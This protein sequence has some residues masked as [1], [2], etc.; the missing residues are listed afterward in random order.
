MKTFYG[1]AAALL[2]M[3]TALPVAAQQVLTVD[4]TTVW[5]PGADRDEGGYA[6][7]VREPAPPPASTILVIDRQDAWAPGF[8][9]EDGDYVRFRIERRSLLDEPV[10]PLR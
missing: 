5:K 9:Y 8:T 10:V 6:M 2:A 7:M 3:A 1:M 4:E